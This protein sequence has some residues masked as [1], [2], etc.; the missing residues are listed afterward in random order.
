MKEKKSKLPH[1]KPV[2]NSGKKTSKKSSKLF[3]IFGSLGLLG[4]A[5]CLTGALLL[6]STSG[7][8]GQK[9]HRRVTPLNLI[10]I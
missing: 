10:A 2:E 7:F 9:F 3:V 4:G 1:K 5:G 6:P 8:N